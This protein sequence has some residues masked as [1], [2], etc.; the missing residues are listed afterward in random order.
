M[1]E[2]KTNEKNK[3][4]KTKARPTPVLQPS[5]SILDV[6]YPLLTLVDDLNRICCGCH[7]SGPGNRSSLLCINTMCRHESGNML[8]FIERSLNTCMNMGPL[9]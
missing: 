7:R 8:L 2:E 1:K 9:I 4:K 3:N 5:N 6:D